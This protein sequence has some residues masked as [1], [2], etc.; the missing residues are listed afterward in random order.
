MGRVDSVSNKLL[1]GGRI[2][3][4]YEAK[5]MGAGFVVTLVVG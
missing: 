4:D 1:F 2:F 3:G 5:R